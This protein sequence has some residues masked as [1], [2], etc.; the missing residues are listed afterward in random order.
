MA[1]IG[2]NDH[3]ENSILEG[4]EE[5]LSRKRNGGYH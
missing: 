4:F 2:L 1:C 3:R 5:R